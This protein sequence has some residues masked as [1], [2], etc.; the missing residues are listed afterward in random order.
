MENK[1]FVSGEYR[2]K[3]VASLKQE[4]QYNRIDYF[5]MKT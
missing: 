4:E 5:I 1:L 2:R 3:E